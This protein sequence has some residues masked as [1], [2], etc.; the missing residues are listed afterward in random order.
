M[1]RPYSIVQADL[2]G[3]GANEVL[4]V[5]DDLDLHLVAPALSNRFESGFSY[6][7]QKGHQH[8]DIPAVLLG[9][10]RPLAMAAG[11]LDPPP[12]D[13]VHAKRKMVVVVVTAGWVVVCLDHNFNVLW[14]TS[15]HGRLPHHA[16]TQ[17]V[18]PLMCVTRAT[19]SLCLCYETSHASMQ[20]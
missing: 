7:K 20:C 15:I 8:I 19:I 13:F 1:V 2:N 18:R 6:A 12:A 3:D 16:A 10:R 14:Q 9:N 17:Q 5:S 4:L 11:Y